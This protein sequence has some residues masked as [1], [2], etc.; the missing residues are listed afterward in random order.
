MSLSFA[1]CVTRDK[2]LSSSIYDNWKIT[3]SQVNKY[4]ELRK[5]IEHFRLATDITFLVFDPNVKMDIMIFSFW[6]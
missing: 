6:K 5:F 1:I 3:P 2:L 4:Y